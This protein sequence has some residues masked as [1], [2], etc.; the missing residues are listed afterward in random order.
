MISTFKPANAYFIYILNIDKSIWLMN[1][2]P[3][4]INLG[5]R[6][7]KILKVGLIQRF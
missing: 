2:L 6:K 4:Q 5:L 3:L 7:L 1:T